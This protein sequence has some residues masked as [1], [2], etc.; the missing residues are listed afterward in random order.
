MKAG[1]IPTRV[2]GKTGE[3][4]TIIGQA[5]GRFPLVNDKEEARAIV[6]RAYEL[7]INYFDNARAT[8]TGSRRRSTATCCR[9]GESRSS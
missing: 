9:S 2:F 4:L 7:G 1:D 8:G 5:G 6:R 3:R